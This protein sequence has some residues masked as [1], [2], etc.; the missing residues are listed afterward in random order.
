MLYH[1]DPGALLSMV[2]TK[3]AASCNPDKGPC[4]YWLL[5]LIH[6]YPEQSS[7]HSDREN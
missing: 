4:G 3:S 2:D 6:L 1:G 7:K 5:N